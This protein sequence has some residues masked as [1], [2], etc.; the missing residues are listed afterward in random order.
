MSALKT[1]RQQ[2]RQRRA[3]KTFNMKWIVDTIDQII[4]ELGEYSEREPEIAAAL[5]SMLASKRLISAYS[6]RML[7]SPY[8]S[9]KLSPVQEAQGVL[10]SLSVRLEQVRSAVDRTNGDKLTDIIADDATDYYHQDILS[11][12]GMDQIVAVA[13]TFDEL[14]ELLEAASDTVVSEIGVMAPDMRSARRKSQYDNYEDNYQ[15]DDAGSIFQEQVDTQREAELEEDYDRIEAETD[16]K[17]GLC[18]DEDG[19]FTDC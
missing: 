11:R 18:R 15:F 4:T 3:S 9:V 14:T 6:Q 16:D 8:K 13:E 17:Y 7:D 2:A 10:N 12:T 19:Q 5:E 1:R